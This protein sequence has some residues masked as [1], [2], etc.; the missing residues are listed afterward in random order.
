MQLTAT[1]GETEVEV[2]T[3][4][5]SL[6]G[7]ELTSAPADSILGLLPPLLSPSSLR[8]FHLTVPVA[9]LHTSRPNVGIVVMAFRIFSARVASNFPYFSKLRKHTLQTQPEG[10]ECPSPTS[11]VLSTPFP[12][13]C[14]SMSNTFS[15]SGKILQDASLLNILRLPIEGLQPQPRQSLDNI[16]MTVLINLA[17]L[18][19]HPDRLCAC[20][21]H[22]QRTSNYFLTSTYVMLGLHNWLNFWAASWYNE[23]YQTPSL[24][25]GTGCGPM[26]LSKTLH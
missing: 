20:T 3:F 11:V 14:N 13:C 2:A 22:T 10:L 24:S 16:V 7:L 23:G 26:R 12:H 8:L 21:T 5:C 9:V 18:Q 15:H 1:A 4:G 17:L 6:F 19:L 25:C